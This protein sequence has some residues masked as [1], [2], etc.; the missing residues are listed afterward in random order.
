MLVTQFLVSVADHRKGI[1]VDPVFLIPSSLSRRDGRVVRGLPE[2][3][4][5]TLKRENFL[6]LKSERTIGYDSIQ[7][8]GYYIVK[9]RAKKNNQ[10]AKHRVSRY[11]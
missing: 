10:P 1:I 8:Y 6:L 4:P 11:K 2:V 7:K 3:L 5:S 9:N